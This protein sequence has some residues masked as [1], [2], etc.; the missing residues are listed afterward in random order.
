MCKLNSDFE[1][2]LKFDVRQFTKKSVMDAYTGFIRNVKRADDA[3][4]IARSTKPAFDR[5]L[6]VSIN[7]IASATC[8]SP[9][10]RV[11][12]QNLVKSEQ[13]QN[14]VI[15]PIILSKYHLIYK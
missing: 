2:K 9:V 4:R 10:P 7:M 14:L 11:H 6:Q 15:M 8:H 3:I 13:L 1:F 12:L 5:F